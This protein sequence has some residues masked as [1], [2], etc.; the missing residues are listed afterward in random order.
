M[1]ELKKF[2]SVKTVKDVLIEPNVAD[3]QQEIEQ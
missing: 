1:V 2:M 3:Q